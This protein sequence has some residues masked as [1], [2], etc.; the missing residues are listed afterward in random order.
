M[1][2]KV[3]EN[4]I[5][6]GNLSF[7]Q[8]L[9]KNYT[10][11]GLNEQEMMCIIQIQ[12]FAADQNYFPSME[13]IAA[14]T[15]LSEAEIMAIVDGLMKKGLLAI[16]K[17]DSQPI[18]SE[19]FS[20]KPLWKKLSLLYW[21]KADEQKIAWKQ[22]KQVNL[23]TIFETEFGRPLSP[24][25]AEMISGWLDQDHLSEEV[26]QEALKEAVIS[27]KVNF[28]YIDRILLNWTKQGVKTSQDAKKIA[29]NFHKSNQQDLEADVKKSD[30]SIPLYDWL[31]KRKG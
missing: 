5:A 8:V 21:N 26:V 30:G 9:L 11:L 31:E 19:A 28:R 1:D 16:E 15:S 14:R 24:M 3:L 25:E 17:N 6:E 18:I 29:E 22:Q 2:E 4:W 12:S 20:L 13:A 23:Y 27:Q 7:P 10:A